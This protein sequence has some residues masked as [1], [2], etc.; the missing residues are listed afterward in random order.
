MIDT[1]NV[2]LGDRS[3]PILVGPG[4]WGGIASHLRERPPARI[5]LVTDAR[6]GSLYGDTVRGILSPLDPDPLYISIPRGE[7]SKSFHQLEN[8]CR[9]MAQA[10]IDR[11]GLVLALG[12]GVVGDLAGFAA[13]TFLRGVRLI[14]MPTT[15]LSMM[16]SSVG[17][18]TGINIPEGKNLVGTFYQPEAVFADIDSLKTLEDRDWYSGLAEAVKIAITLDE[19]LFKYMESIRDLGPRGGL[20]ISR[21]I[22]A[23]CLQKAD[24]VRLDEREGGVRRVLNFGHTLGHGFEGALGYGRIRHGEAVALGMRAALRLS[25][26]VCGLPGNHYDRAMAILERI[27]VP[28]VDPAPGEIEPYLQ[29]DKKSVGGTVQAVLVSSI[30]KAEFVP[31]TTP[32][33][34]ASALKKSRK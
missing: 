4:A 6:V 30:G 8:L 32:E 24:V 16:D 31:L 3:Y 18:K 25:R 23:A 33:L 2:E 5:A 15:L 13:S 21:V 17:G 11:D 1:I 19:S 9:K 20:D 7:K 14:Q 12:G 27:P 22:L 26:D 10:G 34:L 29:R 28:D